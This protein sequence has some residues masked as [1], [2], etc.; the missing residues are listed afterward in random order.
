M[1]VV[2]TVFVTLAVVAVLLSVTSL[3]GE[4]QVVTITTTEGP[5]G[6]KGYVIEGVVTGSV[7][8]LENGDALRL[9]DVASP[10]PGI[11][12]YGAEARRALE[13]LAQPGATAWVLP[14]SMVEDRSDDFAAYVVVDG[15]F[16]N[17]ELATQGAVAPYFPRR[18]GS[19][20]RAILTASRKAFDD[21][22][23]MWGECPVA[24]LD[25]TKP[26]ETGP[27]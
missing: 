2:V 3:T 19:F 5:S 11:D 10:R 1:I 17:V 21:G 25:P 27:A 23:G 18:P 13:Q 14:G 12:C 4:T 9:R 24:R 16:L 20:S 7:L 6:S 15:V 8:K 22:R 26:I